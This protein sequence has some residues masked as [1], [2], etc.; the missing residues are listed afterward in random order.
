MVMTGRRANIGDPAPAALQFDEDGRF[1]GVSGI[2]LP[3]AVVD[4]D[5][6]HIDRIGFAGIH[7]PPA[8]GRRLQPDDP[9]Q[10][11]VFEPGQQLVD[12][13]LGDG[14]SLFLERNRFRTGVNAKPYSP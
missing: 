6:P 8:F 13:V 5:Q 4:R 1:Q 7:H 3:G 2:G 11:T 9:H 10:E 14:D 12:R